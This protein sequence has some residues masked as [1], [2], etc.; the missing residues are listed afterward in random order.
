MADNTESTS[1]RVIEGIYVVEG[2]GGYDGYLKREFI[3][4]EDA[5]D[6]VAT[7]WGRNTSNLAENL[8]RLRK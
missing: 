3:D 5:L 7:L 4:I 6:F 1:I 8:T 2:R